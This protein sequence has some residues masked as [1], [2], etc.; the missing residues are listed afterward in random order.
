M[1]WWKD[2]KNTKRIVDTT[3]AIT[4]INLFKFLLSKLKMIPPAN[5]PIDQKIVKIKAS[6]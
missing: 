5:T 4:N 2:S 6:F 3:S 1:F